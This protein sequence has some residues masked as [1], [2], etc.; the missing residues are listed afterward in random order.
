MIDAG[1]GKYMT[2]RYVVG[3]DDSGPSRRALEWVMSRAD[4]DGI[5]VVVAHVR[6]VGATDTDTD[7][8][9]SGVAAAERAVMVAQQR[10]PDLTVSLQVL[11]GGVVDALLDAVDALAV[12][13]IGTHKTGH[14][15]GRSLGTTGLALATAAP[16]NVVVVPDVDLR[17][18][19]G[20]VAGIDA[21]PV[22]AAV[23]ETA[24][25]EA[26][27]R[28]DELVLV[29]A[30]RTAT[31]A[32]GDL[33]AEGGR[34]QDMHPHLPV[35]CRTT[36]RAIAPTLLDAAL[37][38]ALLVIGGR[39]P[40]EVRA[41]HVSAVLHDVLINLTAPVLVVRHDRAGSRAR[42]HLTKETA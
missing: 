17:F 31:T 38:H 2:K 15:H 20:V 7:V 35:S 4:Y 28:G 32:V 12:L 26:E 34:L 11:G 3:Y 1:K 21:G 30:A 33:A 39:H 14:L 5:P 36:G 42:P 10:H 37:G 18:R 19:R 25:S 13:V 41:G 16:C 22:A 24:A 8:D 29:R 6:R 23:S 9:D 40:S 27:R